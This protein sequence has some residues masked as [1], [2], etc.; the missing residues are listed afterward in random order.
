V[1]KFLVADE[2]R[3]KFIQSEDRLKEMI[4]SSSSNEMEV[5]SIKIEMEEDENFETSPMDLLEIKKEEM[6]SDNDPLGQDL[7]SAE[8]FDDLKMALNTN[9]FAT[10]QPTEAGFSQ[11]SS[12]EKLEIEILES[13]KDCSS[14]LSSK[15]IKSEK[16]T[17]MAIETKKIMENNDFVKEYGITCKQICWI[18]GK[19]FL[20]ATS[21]QNHVS[22]VHSE[23][24]EKFKCP[25]QEC[26]L[27]FRDSSTFVG[28]LKDAHK[29]V[30]IK[31]VNINRK[32]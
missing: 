25:V 29:I 4:E 2:I 19:I 20:Q 1:A 5:D 27:R 7:Q 32:I 11:N 10:K 6:E 3:S 16:K 26:G 31:K 13:K 8:D 24:T 30:R 17:Q 28:H 18:C 22:T 14:T 23:I 9:I 15:G 12:T 21:L